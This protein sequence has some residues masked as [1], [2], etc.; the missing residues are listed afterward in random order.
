MKCAQCRNGFTFSVRISRPF[1]RSSLGALVTCCSPHPGTA[2][3]R[4]TRWREL[5]FVTNTCFTCTII[6]PERV[7]LR[8]MYIHNGTNCTVLRFCHHL[9]SS[10]HMEHALVRIGFKSKPEMNRVS[11]S[12][13]ETG[14]QNRVA[15]LRW[16]LLMVCLY[17]YWR[18]GP[19]VFRVV[20]IDCFQDE[21]KTALLDSHRLHRS[22][23]RDRRGFCRDIRNYVSTHLVAIDAYARK[24]RTP[25]PSCFLRG[26]NGMVQVTQPMT[27]VHS[28]RLSRHL[29]E[30]T[31]AISRAYPPFLRT[32]HFILFAIL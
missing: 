9:A 4:V 24:G 1:L 13:T 15:R 18:F 26:E 14:L 6:V 21:R 7:L 17:L 19:L 5:L 32:E 2:S 28:D 20:C 8:A 10:K 23:K 16:A 3:K 29:F 30:G 11:A 31:V 12:A 25:F 27:A 22:K